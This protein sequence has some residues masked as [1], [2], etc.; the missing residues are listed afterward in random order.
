MS[1]FLFTPDEAFSAGVDPGPPAGD[2]QRHRGRGPLP[3]RGCGPAE[4]RASRRGDGAQTAPQYHPG[5]QGKWQCGLVMS[6]FW[7]KK[8]CHLGTGDIIW[9]PSLRS[10]DWLEESQY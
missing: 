7:K 10:S 9:S 8:C 1:D 4:G 6:L 2:P 3:Q 5:A